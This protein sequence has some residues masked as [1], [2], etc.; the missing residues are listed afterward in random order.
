MRSITL[1]YDVNNALACRKLAELIETG[2]F[3]QT[4]VQ[5][6]FKS[7]EEAAHRKEVEEFLYGSTIMATK[8][9]ANKI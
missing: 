4:V 6:S 3:E 1:S 8:A 5:D 9:F 2:L 7:E